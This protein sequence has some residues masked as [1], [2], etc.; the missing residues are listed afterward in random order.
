MLCYR[1]TF[2]SSQQEPRCMA[3]MCG[4]PIMLQAYRDDKDLYASIASLAFN[5]PYED[6]LEFY[7]DENGHKTDVVNKEGKARRDSAKTILLGMLY[8]RGLNSVAA[9]LHTTKDKAQQIQDKIFKGFPAIK[10]FEEDTIRMAQELG[11]V[12]TFWGRKRRLPDMQKDEFEFAWK[13]GY[14]DVDPLSFD[15]GTVESEVPLRIQNQYLNKLSKAWGSKRREVV[16]DAKKEGIII[17]DNGGKIAEATRQ[18][19]NSRI[20]G[21]AADMSKIAGRLIYDN[22]RLRELGFKLLIPIH[23]EYLAECPKENV[24]ECSKLFAECMCKSAEAL[25]IPIKCD[26]AITE[27]WYGSN[28]EFEEETE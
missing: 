7:L 2:L 14:G 8:G 9:Q 13:K 20:Q 16:D 26:V 4:D 25:N 27:R 19:V 15:N 6:C 5:V 24:K 10:K 12:T 11:Y 22:K 21:S 28:Y 23:D 17:T 1:L 3:A 18:C